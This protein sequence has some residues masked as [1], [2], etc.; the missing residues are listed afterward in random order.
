MY[1]YNLFIPLF[2]VTLCCTLSILTHNS[3]PPLHR[4]NQSTFKAAEIQLHNPWL[5]Y[6]IGLHRLR[7]AG[8]V[9]SI[10]DGLDERSFKLDELYKFCKSLFVGENS[11]VKL[12]LPRN[13]SKESI[14][15]FVHTLKKIVEKEELQWN[16]VK[17]KMM[18]WIDVHMLEIMLCRHHDRDH[19]HHHKR[20]SHSSDSH[21]KTGSNIHRDSHDKVRSSSGHHGEHQQERQDH[22]KRPQRPTHRRLSMQSPS[23]QKQYKCDPLQHFLLSIPTRFP[24]MNDEVEP[25]EY[26]D[27]WQAYDEEAFAVDGGED[28][29]I[30]L[31]RGKMIFV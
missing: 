8:L 11:G 23:D 9:T 30:L 7:E 25:H 31:G 14:V 1:I 24:P 16:P 3:L 22:Q 6:G 28:L 17:K 27:K 29:K 4:T 12:T 2:Q 15:D 26:F 5:T 10:F 18:P 19:H 13:D 21:H 20:E